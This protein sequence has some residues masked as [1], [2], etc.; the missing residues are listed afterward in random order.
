MSAPRVAYVLRAFP[1]LSE[2]FILRELLALR[3]LGLDVRVFALERVA[4]ERMHPEAAR[5][6]PEVTFVEPRASAAWRGLPSLVP[7]K[8]RP[9]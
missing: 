9:A 7:A 1:R 6:L 5:L 2:T 4:G 3:S 8:Q